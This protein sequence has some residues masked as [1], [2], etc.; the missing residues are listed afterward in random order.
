[1]NERIQKIYNA[2][3]HVSKRIFWLN[4]YAI[5]FACLLFQF[6]SLVLFFPRG[7]NPSLVS[8]DVFL[9]VFQVRLYFDELNSIR[10]WRFITICMLKR[11]DSN[12]NA[13]I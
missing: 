5:E 3:E 9:Q 11:C 4:E 2:L 10:Q 12:G 13:D 7:F 6:F 8:V 1:M